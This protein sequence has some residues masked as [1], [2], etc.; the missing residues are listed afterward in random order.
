MGGDAGAQGPAPLRPVAIGLTSAGN[1]AGRDIPRLQTAIVGGAS[2]LLRGVERVLRALF[3]TEDASEAHDGQRPA[4]GQETPQSPYSAPIQLGVDMTH[5]L[6][7]G[8]Q[9]FGIGS[10]AV[11]RISVD[12]YIICS[13]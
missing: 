9:P 4:D 6:L 1:G 7:V 2:A 3:R 8:L 13:N 10:G 11:S 12:I 5:S